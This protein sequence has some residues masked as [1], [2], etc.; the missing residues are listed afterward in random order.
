MNNPS[1][2][3]D[4]T[5]FCGALVKPDG[6]N[7]RVLKLGSTPLYKPIILQSVVAEFIHKAVIDGIGRDSRKR[8]YT[9]E[10]VQTY[11]Q[12]FGDILD[13]KEAKNIGQTYDFVSGFPSDTPSWVVISKFTNIWPSESDISKK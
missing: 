9:P 7:M 5:V 11:L 10:E 8:Y 13:P 1:V 2:L 12:A 6:Y 3:L 4:T